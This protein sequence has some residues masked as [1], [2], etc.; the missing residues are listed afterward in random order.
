MAMAW[1][2]VVGVEQEGREGETTGKVVNNNTISREMGKA[3]G[4]RRRRRA[5]LVGAAMIHGQVL[6]LVVLLVVVLV[7]VDTVQAAKTAV[8]VAAA[9]VVEEEV[10]VACLKEDTK[11]ASSSSITAVVVGLVGVLMAVTT[12]G[13]M[14]V[15]GLPRGRAAAARG[16]GKE[17]EKEKGKGK[18]GPNSPTN[19][20]QAPRVE[21]CCEVGCRLCSA[22]ATARAP[23]PRK[24]I[25]LFDGGFILFCLISLNN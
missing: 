22:I 25:A 12:A 9:V 19:T 14:V 5:M 24:H 1:V 15:D 20:S 2:G 18:A 17:K 6:L 13:A 4:Q 21:S 7:V 8:L 3:G 11:P 10:V 16:K 23:L